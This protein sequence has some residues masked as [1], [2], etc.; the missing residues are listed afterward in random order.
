MKRTV[1]K[2]AI[3]EAVQKIGLKFMWQ[4]KPCKLFVVVNGSIRVIELGKVRS[5]A[6]FERVMGRLEGWSE[7]MAA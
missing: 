7:M 2:A 1:V 5:H 4:D 6:A 3:I